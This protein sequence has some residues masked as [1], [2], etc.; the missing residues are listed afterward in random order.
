MRRAAPSRTLRPTHGRWFRSSSP[1]KPWRR[2]VQTGR[3]T[4]RLLS[5]SELSS[6]AELSVARDLAP[7]ELQ[8]FV[9]RDRR[10]AI[11]RL[12]GD[13]LCAGI[14]ELQA[15]RIRRDLAGGDRFE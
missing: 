8:A 13:E 6:L 11:D 12:G 1:E 5:R 3:A 14:E 10:D 7:A 9:D 4:S 15:L 2:N